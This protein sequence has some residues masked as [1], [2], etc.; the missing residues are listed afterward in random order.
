MGE[1]QLSLS[2]QLHRFYQGMQNR[3]AHADLEAL[4][5]ADQEM[6]AA[7]ALRAIPQPGD[8]A[9]EFSLLDQNGMTVTLG[10]RLALGPVVLLFIRGGWCPFCT[11]SLRA[12]QQALPQLHDA[13]GDLLVVSLQR[14]D[15]CGMVAERDLLAYSMLSDPGGEMSHRYGVMVDLPEVIRPLYLRLGHDLPHINGTGNWRLPLSS[16]FVIARDGRV[17]LAHAGPTQ[18]HRLEPDSAIE[19]VRRLAVPQLALSGGNG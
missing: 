9:P 5:L 4:R 13:G 1:G 15:V 8:V 12:W 7:E 18:R 17:A 16:T 6:A 10:D 19:A 11:L 2:E 3:M 14:V